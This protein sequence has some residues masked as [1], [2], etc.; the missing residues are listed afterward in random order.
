[1]VYVEHA[2]RGCAEEA[3]FTLD[4]IVSL[5]GVYCIGYIVSYRIGWIVSEKT[6][7]YA[8]ADYW[9]DGM[10]GTDGC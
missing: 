8:L 4:H 9:L 3:A 10:D 1:M 6:G 2:S 7:F 5:A